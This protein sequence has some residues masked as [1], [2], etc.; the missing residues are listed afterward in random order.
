MKVPQEKQKYRSKGRIFADILKAVQDEGKARTTHILYKS[1]LSH[2]RLSKYLINLEESGLL[3]RTED[4][5]KVL[6]EITDKGQRFIAE[7]KRM[8]AFADAFGLDI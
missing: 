1:N 2:D 3:V 6:Y 5:E 8:E 7:F 4:G